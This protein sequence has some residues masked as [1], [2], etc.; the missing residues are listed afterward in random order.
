MADKTIAWN[1][2]IQDEAVKLLAVG[3][4]MIVSPTKV[5]YILMTSDGQGLK[6]KFSAKQRSLNKP[7]VVLCSS[8]EQ[9]RN[10][11]AMTDEIDAFYCRHWDDNILLGCILPWKKDAT[12]YLPD[13]ET[14][15]LAMD[16]RQTSC[17]VIKFGTPSELIAKALWERHGK[18]TF[19]SSANP[20]GQGNRGLVEGIGERIYNEADLIISA[21]DYV[22]SIQPEKAPGTRYEQG[23]MISMVDPDGKLVPEQRGQ[24]SVQ[25]APTLIRKGLDVDR[26]MSNLASQ[27]ESW[28]YRHGEYY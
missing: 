5:G 27:F 12:R 28:N 8:I 22:A 11:A 16:T 13:E 9:L 1:G 24:R 2:A 17:F 23:V 10:L 26:I 6:R 20:S 14:A 25:P 4:G 18:L 7:G 3:G 21:N 19:A 15:N